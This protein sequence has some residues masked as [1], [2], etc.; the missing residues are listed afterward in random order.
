[1]APAEQVH[2]GGGHFF[3]M[4]GR[5]SVEACW[6]DS[7]FGRLSARSSADRPGCFLADLMQPADGGTFR[8]MPEGFQFLIPGLA[9]CQGQLVV[10]GGRIAGA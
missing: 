7:D 6:M 10:D 1:M 4:E 3:A 9:K 8:G 2:S 5:Q